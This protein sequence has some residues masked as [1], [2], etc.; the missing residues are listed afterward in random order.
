MLTSF[1]DQKIAIVGAGN[2]CTR[3]LTYFFRSDYQGEKPLIIGVADKNRHAR[4]IILAEE[5]GIPT[6]TDYRAFAGL[7]DLEIIIEMS[8]EPALADAISR[9]MPDNVRVIDHYDARTLWDLLNIQ[10]FRDQCLEENRAAEQL[11]ADIRKL[12]DDLMKR[13]SSILDERT[14]RTRQIVRNLWEQKEM[15][16]QIVQGSTAPTFVIDKNHRITHWNKALE[17]LTRMPAEQVVGTNR[18]WS[19]FYDHPRPTMAD[20]VLD[21]L[22]TNK[23]ARFYNTG[24]DKSALIEG[25]YQ[26]ESF[27][28]KLGKTGK[29]LFFTAA[30]IKAGNGEI[31]GAIETCWDIT[32]SKE[33]AHEQERHNRDL[34]TLVEIYTALNAPGNFEKR[35]DN[36]LSVVRDFIGASNVCIFLK[37]EN[38]EFSLRYKSGTC[39]YA[40]LENE[41]AGMAE[42]VRKMEDTGQLSI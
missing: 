22:E 8:N 10:A 16:S 34:S 38:N 29:W 36:A 37:N 35:L 17:K 4:G 40:C 41:R 19:P 7:D 12:L 27:F 23:I 11:S 24:W 20:I 1:F 18:Q 9:E 28:E 21:Q 3:F 5:L 39:D 30:P 25:A 33:T 13:F 6:T 31:I 2:F 15:V 42:V 14:T 32:K 26:S